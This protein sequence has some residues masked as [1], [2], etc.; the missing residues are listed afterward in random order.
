MPQPSPAPPARHAV[1]SDPTLHRDLLRFARRRLPEHEA[2]DLVQATLAD[3][4]AAERGPENPEEVRKWVHGIA[5][6]KIVDHYRKGKREQLSQ[7]EDSEAAAE[8]DAAGARDLLQWA[9]RELPAGDDAEHTLEW[10][11]REGDG[12]KLEHIAEE[13]SLPAPRVRQRVSRMRKHFRAR[14]AAQLAAAAILAALAV[15]AWFVL[16]K[17]S[18]GPDDIAR[19]KVPSPVERGQELRRRAL[20]DCDA[21]RW[22]ECVRGLDEA[23]RL[24]P[25][26]D[27]TPQVGAARARAAK[28]SSSKGQAPL[29]PNVIPPGP[30]P[31]KKPAPK[32]DKQAPPKGEKGSSLSDT[33]AKPVNPPDYLEIQKKS[34]PPTKGFSIPEQDQNVAP[35]PQTPPQAPSVV[36]QQAPSQQLQQKGSYNSAPTKKS[37]AAPTKTAKKSDVMQGIGISK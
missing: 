32:I 7:P 15:A 34:A 13:A 20:E 9:E 29:T 30:E 11:L 17:G 16:R 19:E 8:S 3:A 6:N 4:L 2:D 24:D 5:R 10:M 1:L 18:P 28:G 31:E 33:N 14:W 36:P 26:G 37:K 27:T 35:Q 23:K 25:A 21:A 22:N 12:E